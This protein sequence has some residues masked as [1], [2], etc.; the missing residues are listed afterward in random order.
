MA[1]K[2]SILQVNTLD[3]I[4]GG[5]AANIAWNLFNSYERSGFNSYLA[6]GHK[7]IHHPEVFQIPK[8]FPATTWQQFWHNRAL[9]INPLIGKVKGAGL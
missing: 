8:Q 1:D 5:G 2:I 4:G 3:K 7:K 6:V 9:S